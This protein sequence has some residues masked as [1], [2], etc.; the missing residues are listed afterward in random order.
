V[1]ALLAADEDTSGFWKEPPPGLA[2]IRE[3][4]FAPTI[5]GAPD[6]SLPGCDLAGTRV[7]KYTIHGLVGKGGMGA[8]YRATREDDFRMEVAIK[9]LKRGTDTDATLERFRS[10][11]QILAGLQHPNIARLIDGGTTDAGLPYLVMEYVDG[12]PLLQHAAP[13]PV[14][15]RLELF[16]AVCHAVQ[17]AHEKRIIHRDIKPANILV[18]PGGVPKL[19][20]FGIAKLVDPAVEAASALTLTGMRLMTPDYASPEQVRGQQITPAT[21]VYSLG[22]VLYE[23]LTGERAHRIQ[24]LSASEI[25]REICTCE[26]TKPSAL[27]KELDSDLDNIVLKALRKE[28]VHFG[29]GTGG[30]SRPVSAGPTGEGAARNHAVPRPQVREA[31]PATGDHVIRYGG[32]GLGPRRW[33]RPISLAGR[34]REQAAVDCSD[35]TRKCITRRWAGTIRRRNDGLSDW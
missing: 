24:S 23:L 3:A 6:D 17:Y 15:R 34:V 35:A 14:R 20:D 33:G 2:E 5:D 29:G 19:L 31:L 11:R 30:R 28:P 18:T 4:V 22:A 10:E 27:A 32:D 7:G 26:P 21:D 12:L 25:E 1:D 13:L 8:V 16:R 9:L